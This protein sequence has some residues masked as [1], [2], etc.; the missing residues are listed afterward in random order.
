MTQKPNVDV[1]VLMKFKTCPGLTVK[2]SGRFAGIRVAEE[3]AVT[4]AVESTVAQIW[5]VDVTRICCVVAENGVENCVAPVWGITI[6]R[7]S[8]EAGCFE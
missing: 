5:S 2:N 3:F 1:L 7:P 4:T 8:R 6:D